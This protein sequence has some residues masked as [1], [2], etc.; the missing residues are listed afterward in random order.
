MKDFVK[1]FARRG[2]MLCGGG[3][4]VLAIVYLCI[5]ASGQVGSL[6]VVR[7]VT[8]ILSSML[9][10]FIA[11]GITAVYTVEKLQLPVAGLIHGSV[12][13]AD[14]LLIYLINGWIPFRPAAVALFVL[15]YAVCFIIIFLIVRK[16]IQIQINRLNR[17]MQQEGML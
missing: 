8:E 5:N 2:L 1:E 6:S 17:Q 11:A 10:A 9:L 3:P 13:L 12:M 16:L 7:I 4:L 15:I 14:Y